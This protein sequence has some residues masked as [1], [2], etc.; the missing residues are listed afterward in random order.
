[1]IEG[2]T[3]DP[4]PALFLSIG[5]LV[6]MAIGWVIGFIDS[7]NRTSKK[8]EAA[9]TRAENAINE[10]A[11]K[12]AA[13]TEVV[14]VMDDP[15]LLRLKH[16]DGVPFL[17]MDGM[18]LNAR[19]VSQEQKKRLIELLNLIRPWIESGPPAPVAPKP[20][21]RAPVQP[22]GGSVGP[23]ATEPLPAVKPLEEKNIRSLS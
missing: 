14:N 3:F 10:A 4:P 7:N 18:S 12:I 5:V 15:G 16:R 22:V 19:S 20:A 21:V 17:E 13:G 9:E 23:N 11:Q 8:I 6:G 2:I 1:M